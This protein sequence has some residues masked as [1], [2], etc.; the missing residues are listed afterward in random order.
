MVGVRVRVT[1]NEADRVLASRRED[2]GEKRFDARADRQRCAMGGGCAGIEEKRHVLADEQVQERPLEVQALMLADDERGVGKR[3][4]LK[5]RAVKGMAVR[6][7]VNPGWRE[8][9]IQCAALQG[10][11]P[12]P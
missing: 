12:R 3:V 5:S 11:L 2:L 4:N 9:V 6:R 7:P 8:V 10:I 1:Y